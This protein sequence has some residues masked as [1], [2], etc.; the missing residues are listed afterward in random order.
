M[1]CPFLKEARVKYCRTSS[2]RKL[3]PAAQAG[4]AEERCSSA[5]HA[6]C[7]I[8]RQQPEQPELPPSVNCPL[9]YESLMQYCGAAPVAKFVP[10][11]ESL[12]SRCGNE[13]HRY[14][15]LYMQMAHAT[16][17]PRTTD[18]IP[19]PRQLGYSAN[20]IWVDIGE[21]GACHAGIDAFF[22]RIL[23][24]VDRVVFVSRRDRHRATAIVTANG[25]DLEITLPMPL[26]VT[27]Y[28]LYLRAN[29]QRL[30]GE[31]Y[32]R[33]WLFAGLPDPGVADG[34]RRGEA[35]Q[36]WMDS[37]VCAINQFLRQLPTGSTAADGG[38][39]ADGLARHLEQEHM[40][41]LFHEF[42][43]PLREQEL[44]P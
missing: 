18:G 21:D 25:F 41:A 31:P 13:G 27:G 23:G 43:S 34:L 16:P 28:N 24:K 17:P 26:R 5:S 2:I 33:G 37:E 30:I 8:F 38:M 35:A 22:A 11:S 14:C 9:L 6:E 15:E 3:I 42:F 20:H 44:R 36:H 40:L 39:F 19:M 7:P 29:P 1:T 12:L 4:R 32:T 10:Y